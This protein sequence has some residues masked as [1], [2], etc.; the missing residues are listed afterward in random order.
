MSANK[1]I[2]WEI[3]EK[4]KEFKSSGKTIYIFVERTNLDGYHFAS[5]ADKIILDDIGTFTM[6]G[7]VSGRSYYKNLFAKLHIGFDELRYFKY[8]S[9]VESYARDKMSEADREQRQRIIDNWYGVTKKEICESRNIST[10]KYE[11]LINDQF[12]YL[13]KTA[14]DMKLVDTLGRW[15]ECNEIVRKMDSRTGMIIDAGFLLFK[16]EP[17]DDKWSEPKK[18]AIVYAI[19]DCD[20]ESG[21]G[22]RKL[23][24]DLKIAYARHDV[25]AIVLR[26]D[27][28]GGDA[29]ASDY[30][31]KIIKENKNRK[32]LIV[33]QGY[34]AASGGYWLSM[35]GDKIVSTPMTLTGSIGVIGGWIYDKGLKDT[36]GITTDYVK[37][38]KYA[39]MGFSFALPLIGI[40]L[41]IRDLND[42]EKG[43]MEKGIKQM[44]EEFVKKVADGRNK[45]YDDIEKIAQGRVWTG[46]DALKNGLVD[47]LGGLDKAIEIAKVAARIE[48][49][50]EVKFIEYPQPKMFDFSALAS[51]VGVKVDYTDK[52][53]QPLI[54]R[55]KNNGIPMPAMSFD[56]IDEFGNFYK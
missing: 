17:F 13:P 37:D 12:M 11:S 55:I 50:E 19:G 32:P 34:V 3:R 6:E 46:E 43:Q 38:G 35:Y 39:D 30:I 2:E 24:D 4:L 16:N 9:A 18:I 8:K 40:G 15:N 14:I 48:K 42:D 25:K 41:P 21:I 5:V 36:I 52:L 49:N 7:Y 23:A 29:M 45:S 10:D 47:E 26:V 31:S 53:M 20:M 1:S 28:P 33:S 51:M 56:F 54:Y 44:Y 22:A 27:S